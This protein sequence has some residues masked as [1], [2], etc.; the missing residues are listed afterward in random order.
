MKA[1]LFVAAAVLVLS[2]IS[3]FAQSQSER[4]FATIKSLAGEWEGKNSMGEAVRVSYRTT[5]GGS[6]VVSE[7]QSQMKGRSEDMTSMIHLDRDRLLLTHYCAVGNQPR[8]QATI[9]PDGKTIT[10]DFVDA[11]NLD[12]P[13]AGHMQRVVF[14]IRDANHHSEDWH[15]LDHGKEMVEKFDL[16]RKS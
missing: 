1:K 10:F 13:D 11:T 5:A 14:T 7:I 8:M 15:F 3:V 4:T 16:E 2:G 12:S 6:A 9:S